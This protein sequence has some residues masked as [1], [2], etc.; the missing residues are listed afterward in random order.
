MS[1]TV[2]KNECLT[3]TI[4]SKGAEIKSVKNNNG[5]EFMWEADPKFW[6]FS[7]PIL[8]P[9]CGGLREDKFFYQGKEYTLTKHGYAK[10]SE[11]EVESVC[12]NEAVFLLRSN[13]E[14]K[15]CYPFDYEFRAKYTLDKNSLKVSYEVTNLTDGEM[16]TDFGGHEAYACPG[17]IGGY[18]V[19]FDEKENLDAACLEGNHFN[20]ETHRVGENTNTLALNDE[21]FK[22]DALAFLNLKSRGVVLAANDGSRK[23]RV[24][25][26]GHPYVLLW[27]TYTAPYLCI[28]PWVGMPDRVDANQQITDKEGIIKIE[29]DGKF[30]RIHTITF[31]GE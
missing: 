4:K 2:I 9:I 21:F 6:G 28:E 26:P 30:E 22:T 25:Y 15:K 17:G 7:A 3:V 27:T 29:K 5:V 1:E 14:T 12:E 19:I 20:Y 31:E 11:F 18:S 23:I 10:L 24:D 13:E 16:Y 8:F